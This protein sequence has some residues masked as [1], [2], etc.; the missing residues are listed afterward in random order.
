M[1]KKLTIVLFVFVIT[2]GASAKHIVG[3]EITYDY[4]GA[5]KYNV[6]TQVFRNCSE[7]KFN[8]IGGG[9]NT[10]SCNE[11]NDLE[12]WAYD[13]ILL[14]YKFLA[15]LGNTRLSITDKT[16]LCNGE[17]S[18]CQTPSTY[19]YGI[20]MH[21][22]KADL[23]LTTYFDLGYRKFKISISIDSRSAAVNSSNTPKNHFNFCHINARPGLQ[24]S[25]PKSFGIPFN[26]IETNN[27]VIASSA[28]QLNN[29]DSVSY[30]LDYAHVSESA[31][32]DYLVGFS[33]D[34]P[35]VTLSGNNPDA[36]PPE[37]LTLNKLSGQISFTPT[38][39]GDVGIFVIK[40]SYFKRI[41]GTIYLI[42]YNRKDFEYEVVNG[43]NYNPYFLGGTEVWNACE[44]VEFREDINTRDDKFMGVSDTVIAFQQAGETPV[45]QIF[46]D[47]IVK[48]PFRFYTFK[49]LPPVGSA[50]ELPY[51]FTIFAQD[52]KCPKP[53]YSSHVYR[54]KVGVSKKINTTKI[55]TNCNK[56]LFKTVN[57]AGKDFLRW[58]I[59]DSNKNEMANSS[60]VDTLVEF[61]F[62]SKGKW[63]V[64]LISVGEGLA[65]QYVHIDSVNI[66][67]FNQP[68]VDLGRD[69][70]VCYNNLVNINSNATFVNGPAS[71]EWKFNN[72]K[73]N[74]NTATLDTF[75]TSNRN[76]KVKVTDN[77]GCFVMDTLEV[78][79]KPKWNNTVRDSGLCINSKDSLYLGHLIDDTLALSSYFFSGNHVNN[80]RFGAN[81][82]PVGFYNVYLSVV[83]TV[84]C[85]YQ[86]TIQIEIGIPFTINYTPLP[87]K[88]ANNPSFK[89]SMEANPTPA[90]GMW[91]CPAKNQLVRNDSFISGLVDSGTFQLKYQV[92]RKGCSVDTLVS[93]RILPIPPIT[94][95]NN[96]PDRICQ[97]AADVTITTLENTTEI[98][99]NGVKTNKFAPRLTKD[100]AIIYITNT[101]SGNGCINTYKKTIY[102]D[103]L[104]NA[105]LEPV[106]DP[107]CYENLEVVLQVSNNKY[108]VEWS[109]NGTGSFTEI[110]PIY[111]KYEFSSTEKSNLDSIAIN[112]LIK[113]GN[114]CPNKNIKYVIH[115]NAPFISR[116]TY[117]NIEPCELG[118]YRVKVNGVN[119]LYYDSVIWSF[120]NNK[121]ESNGFS[122][123]EQHFNQITS[124]NHK[125]MAKVYKNGCFGTVDSLITIY[126]R[127]KTKVTAT[128]K[129]SYSARYPII[130]FEIIN[131][132]SNFTYTWSSIPKYITLEGNNPYKF[133]MPGDTGVHTFYLTTI[134]DKGCKDSLSYSVFCLPKDWIWV[135]NAFTPNNDGPK[136]NDVFKAEGR[137][138]SDFKLEIF[139]VWGEKVFQSDNIDMG[140]D[141]F[142]KG[143]KC[144]QGN[145]LYKVTFIDDIGRPNL[146]SGTLIM[147]P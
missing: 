3:S 71:I 72:I 117:S 47:T 99:V 123:N 22:F 27:P 13:S 18:K 113:S 42:G 129:E 15:T 131:Q 53:G 128:P 81:A 86:D 88:C 67:N 34:S 57:H 64:K 127:P 102:V 59:L 48:S 45:L 94:L 121:V 68:T 80:N 33:Y 138:S 93:L 146:L 115:Q 122:N 2:L 141:G 65:C 70:I 44:N 108:V 103:S 107:V 82:L 106:K 41:N 116:L 120:D 139:N 78:I 61:T 105:V 100:S 32:N 73:I 112:L 60:V 87:S 19:G 118:K 132:N 12:L 125:I 52:S 39:N 145:Y 20:E 24:Q 135:P 63:Y 142:Y 36:N 10:G 137:V 140:W 75:F 55:Q 90:G 31:V 17:K 7:C 28:N 124:G 83:D 111:Y 50:R 29:Y 46:V 109:T 101:H 14:Q 8:G 62:P 5:N 134:S 21:L 6:F 133:E 126:A 76:I 98:F 9:S 110:T 66:A 95:S 25:S 104:V 23:D 51:S 1:I 35:V 79:V 143:V 56:Y 38:A 16:I 58:S 97:N 84:S 4:L 144:R 69:K 89:L 30:T 37:G 74:H 11:I 147:L 43:G 136:E 40:C 119:H 77:L 130:N 49:W 114:T 85:S 92:S 96:L 26:R 91:T 54:I